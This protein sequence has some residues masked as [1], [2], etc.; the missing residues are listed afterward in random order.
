MINIIEKRKK[1][2][3]KRK[4]KKENRK[5]KKEKRKKKKMKGKKKEKEKKNLKRNFSYKNNRSKICNESNPVCQIR[6]II[7]YCNQ[8]MRSRSDPIMNIFSIPTRSCTGNVQLRK[9]R[10]YRVKR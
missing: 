2:K 8:S 9:M 5:K 3:E 10:K 7:I 4:K 1:K 6:I